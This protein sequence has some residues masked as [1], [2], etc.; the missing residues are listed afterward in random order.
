MEMSGLDVD[1]EVPIEIAALVTDQDFKELDQYHAVIKQPQSY[2]EGMDDW[3]K[4]Q[5]GASGLIALMP[6]GKD[7][8]LVDQ[9]LA[10]FVTRHF[11]SER[12]VLAGNSIP[13]DRL[14]IRRYLKKTEATL[15]YRMLDVTA[16]KVIFNE[17]YDL[18][19][20]KKE[21]HRA[22]DDVRESIAELKFYLTYIDPKRIDPKRS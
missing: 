8:D 11:G 5:H 17:L 16:W 4:R 6:S 20:K 7:P 15:H 13:Q 9:E 21:G 12:A 2:I 19:F 3:N 22:L 1:K 14:F 18:K 10:A